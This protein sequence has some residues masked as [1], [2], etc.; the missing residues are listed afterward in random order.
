[1]IVPGVSIECTASNAARV[2]ARCPSASPGRPEVWPNGK[3]VY[4]AR[5]G[6]ADAVMLH[7]LVMHTVGIPEASI[8]RAISPTD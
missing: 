3:S 4:T 2:I 1:M 5:D 6:L 7:A 8:A